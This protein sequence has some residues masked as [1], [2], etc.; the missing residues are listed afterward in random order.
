MSKFKFG[1]RPIVVDLFSG[2]GGLSLGF[3][4]AGFDIAAAV[5]LDPI[6][7]SVHDF[8]FPYCKTICSDIMDVKTSSISKHLKSLGFEKPDVIVGGPPC[9][10]FSQ[11]GQRQLDDPR[12]NLVFEFVKVVRDLKPKYFL[13]ENV[14]GIASGKHVKFIKELIDEFSSVGYQIV[15]HPRTLNS[16]DYGVAQNRNRFILIGWEKGNKPVDYPVKTHFKRDVDGQLSFQSDELLHR[17]VKS[18]LEDLE[19]ISVFHKKDLGISTGLLD[20][21]S[22][23]ISFSTSPSA[24]FEL[25]HKRSFKESLVFGHLGSKHTEKSQERFRDT[26]QGSSEKISR[27]FKLHPQKPCNTLRAGTDS[28]RGAHTAPRPIHYSEHRCI[29]VREA[30]RLHSYPDWFQFHRTIWHGFREIGNSVAPLFA[31]QLATVIASALGSSPNENTCQVLEQ[32]DEKLLTN[33]MRDACDYFGV[34]YNTIGK[35]DRNYSENST[36]N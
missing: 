14:P 5:E 20:Y 19:K 36:K 34:P 17:G 31:K 1:K 21:N 9:Q 15:A 12:N 28:K 33:P 25:C 26:N 29:T 8:N 13:F 27:F 11:I 24:D 23:R 3:E 2:A 7:C 6:H 16:A 22:E 10:G 18:V 32:A 30:A 35:R 4:A